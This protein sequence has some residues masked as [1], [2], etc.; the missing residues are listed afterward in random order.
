MKNL[1]CLTLRD[2][3]GNLRM[4]LL[5]PEPTARSAVPGVSP[6]EGTNSSRLLAKSEVSYARPP[7][8]LAN[9]R[10]SFL[11]SRIWQTIRSSEH[12]RHAKR[13]ELR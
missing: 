9:E 6:G 11:I 5:I 1:C 8:W 3:V 7:S 4:Q 12:L 13:R 10:W 2:P